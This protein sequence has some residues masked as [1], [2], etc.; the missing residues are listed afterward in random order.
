M[1]APEA[2]FG[3]SL[4]CAVDLWSLGCL[5]FEL[6]TGRSFIRPRLATRVRAIEGVISHLGAPPTAW[7]RLMPILVDRYLRLAYSKEFEELL[8][9]AAYEEGLAIQEHQKPRP[10]FTDDELEDLTQTLL[11]LLS[12]DPTSRGTPESVLRSRWFKDMGTSSGQG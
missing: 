10:E 3:L 7:T 12:Y 11:G 5:F 8:D 9:L 2:L 6:I 4:S 1:C